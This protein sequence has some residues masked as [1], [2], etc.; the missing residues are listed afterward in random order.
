MKKNQ[1]IKILQKII[2]VEANKWKE[3]KYSLSGRKNTLGEP[4]PRTDSVPYFVNKTVSR[5][6]SQKPLQYAKL[7]K[8]N[9]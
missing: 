7:S 6:F 4:K 3:R 9:K 5:D 1:S 2:D 8:R